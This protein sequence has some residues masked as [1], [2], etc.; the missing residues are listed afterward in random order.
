MLEGR[1]TSGFD[2]RYANS[3][4]FLLGA[5]VKH[6]LGNHPFLAFIEPGVF[7][8]ALGVIF[9]DDLD[10][11]A[12]ALDVGQ[13]ERVTRVDDILAAVAKLIW[14]PVLVLGG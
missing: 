1:T 4:R 13:G 12:P 3:R 9:R 2:P 7:H 11:E 14:T 5:I 10:I 6:G 8:F